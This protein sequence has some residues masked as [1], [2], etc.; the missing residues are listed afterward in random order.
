MVIETSPIHGTRVTSLDLAAGIT[1][2]TGRPIDFSA[3]ER[4]RKYPF[5]TMSPGDSFTV[6]AGTTDITA[7]RSNVQRY[8]ERNPTLQYQITRNQDGGFTVTCSAR[9]LGS[10]RVPPLVPVRSN[11]NSGFW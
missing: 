1:D 10:R 3:G 4:M 6:P 8:R 9:M 11:G 2:A 7:L 5:A